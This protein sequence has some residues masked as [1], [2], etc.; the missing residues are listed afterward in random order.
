VTR[1]NLIPVRE[2]SDQHLMAEYRELPRMAHFA[3]KTKQRKE[4]I[5]VSFTL[6][7]GHMTFFL[8]KAEF[9]EQRHAEIV[10]EC[11]RRGIKIKNTDRFKMPRTFEQSDWVPTEEEINVSRERIHEK[12]AMKPFFYKWSKNDATLKQLSES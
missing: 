5:P 3:G 4:D 12:L 2:L 1:I 6:N 10:E 7:K 11:L 8:D 9:L